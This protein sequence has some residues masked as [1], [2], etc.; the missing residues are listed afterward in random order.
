MAA[1]K[2]MAAGEANNYLVADATYRALGGALAALM[3]ATPPDLASPTLADALSGLKQGLR[4]RSRAGADGADL[5]RVLPMAVS[6]LMA[7]W[8]ESDALRAAVASRG[9]LYSSFGPLA[10]G[11]AS[12]LLADGAGNEGG[13]AGQAVFARGGPG[14]VGGALAAAARGLGVEFR[15]G[16]E[17]GAVRNSGDAVVGVTLVG[18]DE[19]DAGIVVSGADPR[20]TLLGLLSPEVVGP[21]LGWRAGNIRA[22]GAT[23]KV[24]SRL[25]R[26]AQVHCRGR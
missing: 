24:E 14:A 8:F 19:I 16:A 25:V 4:A 7:E 10:P 18:G 11:T 9:V 3:A 23:A 17:V 13:L 21:R 1:G 2:H 5:L 20:T 12:V 26:P 15:T 22:Y 6:D